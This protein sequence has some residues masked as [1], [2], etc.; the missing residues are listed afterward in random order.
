MTFTENWMAVLLL[1]STGLCTIACSFHV[2][3]T[4]IALVRRQDTPPSA[5]R[6]ETSLILFFVGVVTLT[7][8]V[9][10]ALTHF[11]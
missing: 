2:G 7:M 1:L 6:C 10:T 3:R 8:F 4:L 11:R 9:S 5:D